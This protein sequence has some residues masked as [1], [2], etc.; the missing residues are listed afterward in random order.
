MTARRSY[1]GGIY[2]EDGIRISVVISAPADRKD[3][4]ELGELAQAGAQRTNNIVAHNTDR[5]ERLRRAEVESTD[6]ACTHIGHLVKPY[7]A[8][9]IECR[10]CNANLGTPTPE[11]PF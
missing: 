5:E 8:D 2:R 11:P 3:V 4:D 7:G 9:H 6:P 10:R 1:V